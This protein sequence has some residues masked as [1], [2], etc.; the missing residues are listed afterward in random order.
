MSDHGAFEEEMPKDVNNFLEAVR[1]QVP[2]QPDPRLEV[3]LVAR[4]AAIA[5]TDNEASEST[6]MARPRR[7]FGALRRAALPARIALASLGLVLS[8]AGMAVAGVELPGP[9]DSTFREVGIELPNQDAADGG[10]PAAEPAGAPSQQGPG[11]NG[12]AKQKRGGKDKGKLKA[13][14]PNGNANGQ[15]GSG[16]PGDS[17][18]APGRTKAKGLKLGTASRSGTKRGAKSKP[19][20]P[21]TE[22]A[23][24]GEANIG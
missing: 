15:Q 16:S 19:P 21:V 3:D 11:E 2:E 6:P 10:S 17:G 24:R 5:H 22:P 4:M 20:K 14:G 18:S 1:V 12:S 9:I 13:H 7:R 23:L 8:T